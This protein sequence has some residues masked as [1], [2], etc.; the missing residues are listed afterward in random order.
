M[1]CERSDGPTNDHPLREC[2]LAVLHENERETL[3]R[4]AVLVERAVLEYTRGGATPLGPR[5]VRAV[6]FDVLH[7]LEHGSEACR[8]WQ[9]LHDDR[10]SAHRLLLEDALPHLRAA[11][12]ALAP[13]IEGDSPDW[14]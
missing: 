10:H 14:R 2:F 12:D 5:L 6:A 13:A 7:A 8:D 1:P 9:G 4:A 11:A 3:L